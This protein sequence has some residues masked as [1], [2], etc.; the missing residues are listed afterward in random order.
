MFRVIGVD[1]KEYGPVS[2]GQLRNWIL[3]GRANALTR[4]IVEGET[5]WKSLGSIPE[6]SLL[7]G[8]R[9]D[10]AAG[11]T[12]TPM[13]TTNGPAISGL[14]LGMVSFPVLCCCYGLPFNLLG[15]V[16][17]IVGMVET[18]KHPQRYSGRGIAIAGFLISLLSLLLALLLYLIG[19]TLEHAAHRLDAL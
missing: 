13:R 9:P 19:T 7:L 15:L 5:H 16:L 17:A 11:V 18:K 14:V 2:S 1:G 10:S 4:V 6:F 12:E 3:E 8:S